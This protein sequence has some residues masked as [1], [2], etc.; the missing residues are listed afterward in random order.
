MQSAQNA[1]ELIDYVKKNVRI[2]DTWVSSGNERSYLHVEENAE[3]L[4]RYL[5]EEAFLSV[6]RRYK[7]AEGKDVYELY[8]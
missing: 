3:V 5:E 6:C 2:V 8:S 1:A 7:N 4:C